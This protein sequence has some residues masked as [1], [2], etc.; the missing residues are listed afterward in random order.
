MYREFYNLLGPDAPS[1][2]CPCQKLAEEPPSKSSKTS[3]DYPPMV[4]PPQLDRPP[5]P[6][7]AGM[8]GL[9]R[10]YNNPRPRLRSPSPSNRQQSS[11][12]K[13]RGRDCSVDATTFKV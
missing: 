9:C 4:L 6:L 7:K 2:D 11:R 5:K 3:E 13:P 12:T 10:P 8:V 1:P